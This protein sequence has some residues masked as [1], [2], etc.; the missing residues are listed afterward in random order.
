MVTCADHAQ[1]AAAHIGL[2]SIFQLA[3]HNAKYRRR[4]QCLKES[5]LKDPLYSHTGLE[6][7]KHLKV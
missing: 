4:L 2:E 6:R 3:I 5:S 7:D 1:N